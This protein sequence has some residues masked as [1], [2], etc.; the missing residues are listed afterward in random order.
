MIK[1][2]CR[3]SKPGFDAK[4]GL[5]LKDAAKTGAKPV[6]KE[7]LLPRDMEN[8]GEDTHTF[9]SLVIAMPDRKDGGEMFKE[10]ENGS[11]FDAGGIEPCKPPTVADLNK[12]DPTDPDWRMTTCPVSR[13]KRR[14]RIMTGSPWKNMVWFF[15]STPMPPTNVLDLEGLGRLWKS[16]AH[17]LNR[18]PCI[19]T[20]HAGEDCSEFGYGHYH[21]CVAVA[22]EEVKNWNNVYY[23][24]SSDVKSLGVFV[25]EKVRSLP[26]FL[27][28]IVRPPRTLVGSNNS[29]MM[30]LLCK[31][32]T[33]MGWEG[34]YLAETTSEYKKRMRDLSRGLYKMEEYIRDWSKVDKQE[35]AMSFTFGARLIPAINH[36]GILRGV[37]YPKFMNDVRHGLEKCVELVGYVLEQN[38]NIQNEK[39]EYPEF[40]QASCDHKVTLMIKEINEMYWKILNECLIHTLGECGKAADEL[41]KYPECQWPKTTDWGVMGVPHNCVFTLEEVEKGEAAALITGMDRGVL[42]ECEIPEEMR[43]SMSDEEFVPPTTDDVWLNSRKRSRPSTPVPDSDEDVFEPVEK[44]ERTLP[45]PEATVIDGEL[46]L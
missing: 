13:L 9:Y 33:K 5:A 42:F 23:K 3:Y 14:G 16:I 43:R 29:C 17:I 40:M 45:L 10:G 2:F 32:M 8:V 20:R 31:A 6:F 30:M 12:N 1:I 18:F 37:R 15:T 7:K 21:A 39:I 46:I 36:A 34:T 28:Y 22:N 35:T 11:W 26:H 27:S 44:K 38:V 4:T 24:L 41:S 19:V 25:S